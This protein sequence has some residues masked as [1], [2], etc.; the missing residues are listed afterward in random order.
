ML[1]FLALLV[2]LGSLPA[3]LGAE[4]ILVRLTVPRKIRPSGRGISEGQVIYVVTVDGK[5]FTLHLRKHSF[6]SQNFLIYTYN[7][8]GSL[9]SESSYFM[10]HCH[11]QGYIAEFPNSV[12]SLSIC[13]GLRGFL[14]LENITY[15][16]EPLESSAKFE[17]IIYQVKNGNLDVPMLAENYGSIWQ[18]DQLY[19]IHLN[20]QEKAPSKL[21][22][23][24]L[25]MHIIV[26]KAL[27]DYM[28]SEMMAV[29]QKIIQ[30]IGLVNTM[31]A[32]FKLTV[33][34]S[35]VELWTHANQILTS[36][37]ADDV[38]QRFLEWKQDHL[39]LRPHD[40]AHLLIYREH[41]KYA[42][43][44]FPGRMCTKHYDA[45]IVMYP[46]YIS[47][48]GFSVV[49][50]QLL[51][52]NMG[53]TYDDISNCSC[54][55]AACIMQQGAVSSSGIKIFSNCSRDDYTR[56]ISKYE[57]KCLHD[58][59]TVQPLHQ[60]QPVC[61]NGILEPDEE[62][63][64]GVEKECQFKKCCDY[65]TC[66]L[67][68]SATCGSGACCT[69][70]CE[71]SVAGTP[72]R[73]S[74]DPECDFTEYCN[75]TSSHCV[76]DTYALNGHLCRMGSAYCYGGQCQ[77]TDYQ[78]AQLFGKGAQGAPYDCFKEVNSAHQRS[79]NCGFKNSQPLP[80]KPKDVL[81]GILA[82]TWLHK[83]IHK[84]AARSAVYS[85]IH[86]HVCLSLTPGSSMREDGR[87]NAF[88]A[89]GTV[90]GPQ[91]YC[92]NQTCRGAHLMGYNCNATEKCKGNGICNNLGNCQC[93]PGHRPPDC[94][95]QIGAPGGS[96]DDGNVQKSDLF[97]IKKGFRKHW[98]NW[99]ILGFY[100]FLPFLI[101]FAIMIVKRQEA[102]KIVQQ[103]EQ[104]MRSK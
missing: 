68:S 38:L 4:G 39:T 21:L 23:K 56:I 43:A 67:K 5:P 96:V 32:N 49:I 89:D 35:S 37:D 8:A 76:P 93:F 102:R 87:D 51:G 81:C 44:T 88:V 95:F 14:Q 31:F 47:L 57:T 73:K 71:F 82:C 12:V 33:L 50:T 15:G 65:Q 1:L 42:G 17:H 45:G 84:S 19:K 94:N 60:T 3:G 55:R 77:A 72:C 53:L 25:Q 11:Y 79:G 24:C 70:K 75:G 80:C 100:I 99:L 48:E 26:E 98:D 16:I 83:H 34:L 22:P 9:H 69:S 61:G 54:P 86:D 90:C 91:M 36:G 7:E 62:C 101:T 64:C 104:S 28:G 27:Y 92:I 18:N 20:Y 10:M 52:L 74:L 30:I 40:V 58:I 59:S 29:T 97:L 46:D 103:M 41:P 63:D 2:E 13:S 85:F 78:C 6:L 66:K